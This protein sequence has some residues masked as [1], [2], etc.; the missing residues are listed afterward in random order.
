MNRVLLVM[1]LAL[2]LVLAACV[3]GT[4]EDPVEEEGLRP[5]VVELV[6]ALNGRDNLKGISTEQLINERTGNCPSNEF[7]IPGQGARLKGGIGGLAVAPYPEGNTPGSVSS[8]SKSINTL[9][10]PTFAQPSAI[11]VIDDFNGELGSVPGVYFPDQA[12][13]NDL[14]GLPEDPD[15]RARQ[16]EI[17]MNGLEA[18]RQLSHGALVFNHTLALLNVLDQDMSFDTLGDTLFA[19]FPNLGIRVFAVDTEDFNTGVIA[20]RAFATLRDAAREFGISRFAVNL[21]FGLVPCSVREDFRA[22]KENAPALT[23]EEYVNF[24]LAANG[25]A[26][27]F[28]EELASLLTTPLDDDPLLGL[29]QEG[30]GSSTMITYAAAAGNYRHAWSLAPGYW[31]EFVSVSAENLSGPAGVKDLAYSNTGEVLLPGGYFELTF[32]DL[33]NDTWVTYPDISVA[34]T[35]FAAPVLSVFT[36]LDYSNSTP[37]CVPTPPSP[38]AFFNTDPPISTPLPKLNEPLARALQAYCKP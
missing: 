29:A 19:E 22:S 1:T 34:G 8:V 2:S 14:L 30:L 37:R 18:N 6:N 36:A 32:Y 16:Q 27:R 38:L 31:P 21:S 28:R 25:L 35:S 9:A 20:G 5:A 3:P 17:V 11:L 4:K 10:S 33:A 12:G 7:E 26:E 13:L 24:V 23:F 15:E